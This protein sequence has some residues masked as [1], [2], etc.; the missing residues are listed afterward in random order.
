MNTKNETNT[1]LQLS[2]Y[3]W[4]EILA[5][6]EQA[7]E[8]QAK[9]RAE[10]LEEFPDE[11]DNELLRECDDQ[12]E[13]WRNLLVQIEAELKY[14]ERCRQPREGL[15]YGPHNRMLCDECFEVEDAVGG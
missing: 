15:I 6:L 8:D 14:C 2:H 7:L 9:E 4:R 5:L 10:I 3:Y 13:V 11:V 12:A 1:S